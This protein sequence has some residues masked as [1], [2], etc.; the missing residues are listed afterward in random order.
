MTQVNKSGLQV[1]K[2]LVDFIELQVLPG[3]GLS[4][5]AFWA[6]FA[7]LVKRFQPENKALLEKRV[8]LQHQIDTWHL[9]NA[10]EVFDAAAYEVFL[11]K[12]GYIVAE[13]DDFQITTQNVDLEVSEIA[14]PQ[15]VVPITNARFAL[16]A[17]NARWG[18]LFDALYGTDALG[19]TAKPCLL[20]TSPS[21]RDA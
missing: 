21:P 2:D 12:I 3:T 16:N 10:G 17:A 8:A 19:Q 6:G 4:A 11:R 7:D 9:E 20:Y 15:L 1:D 5:V 18:S 14:G 13:G